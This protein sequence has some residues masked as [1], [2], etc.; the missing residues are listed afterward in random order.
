VTVQ[1]RSA[2][3]VAHDLGLTRNAVYIANSRV[4]RRLRDELGNLSE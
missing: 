2:D 3:D 4:L 1:G